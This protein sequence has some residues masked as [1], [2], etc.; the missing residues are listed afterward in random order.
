[1]TRRDSARA[2]RRRVTPAEEK[3][4]AAVRNRQLAGMKF[5]RQV[6]FG[7]FVA[8]FYCL[9]KRIVVELDGPIYA[10]QKEE[11]QHRDDFMVACGFRVLRLTNEEVVANLEGVLEQIV[12]L[13]TVPFRETLPLYPE[14]ERVGR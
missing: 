3:L 2:L 5:R 12:S 9:E 10:Q 1:M 14:G 13:A 8:D 6:P 4:R 7:Q 11:D